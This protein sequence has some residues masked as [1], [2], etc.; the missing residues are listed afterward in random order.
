VKKI[1]A[2]ISDLRQISTDASKSITPAKR[3]L[4]HRLPVKLIYTEKVTTIKEAKNREKQIKSFKG[5]QA[6]KVLLQTQG[7]PRPRLDKLH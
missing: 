6:F 3:S 7:S 1:M 5:G 2:F 4:K